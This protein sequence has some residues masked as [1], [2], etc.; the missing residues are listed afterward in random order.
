MKNMVKKTRT[1]ALRRRLVGAA[2]AVA[3]LGLAS[4]RANATF[5]EYVTPAGSMQNGLPVDALVDITTGAGTVSVTLENLEA[6][7]K[8]VAQNLS[9]LVIDFSVPVG[10]TSLTSS[11]G[12]EITVNSNGTFSLGGS[13]AT[14]WALSSLTNAITLDDLAG[15]AAPAHT[16]IGPPDGSSLYSNANSSIAGNGPHNPFLNQTATFTISA[17]GVTANTTVTGLVFSF[18]TEAGFNTTGVAVPEPSS[19]VLSGTGLVM[20]LGWWLRH[21]TGSALS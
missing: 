6:N 7:P 2:V 15:G 17:A 19:L 20:G 14:G 4:P 18:N 21:R 10:V 8:S 1:V 9:N 13:V 12:Q 11:A 3:V 5:I 16:L